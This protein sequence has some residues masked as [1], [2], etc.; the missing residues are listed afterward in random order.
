MAQLVCEGGS[1]ACRVIGGALLGRLRAWKYDAGVPR[2]L[3]VFTVCLQPEECTG[4]LVAV[5]PRENPRGAVLKSRWT[6]G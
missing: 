5:L 3:A 2:R 6:D 4:D 1:V